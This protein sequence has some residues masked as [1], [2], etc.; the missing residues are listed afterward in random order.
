MPAIN[1][2]QYGSQAIIDTGGGS[3]TRKESP[4][5]KEEVL[6]WGLTPDQLQDVSYERRER[7]K[8]LAEQKRNYGKIPSEHYPGPYGREELNRDHPFKPMS[9]KEWQ[10]W[11]LSILEDM[12]YM[13]QYQSDVVAHGLLN[14]NAATYD[15]NIYPFELP[16]NPWLDYYGPYNNEPISYPSEL[17]AMP[18]SWSET[19][20]RG[21]YGASLF[22]L[23]GSNA[24]PDWYNFYGFPTPNNF[25]PNYRIPYNT[26]AEQNIDEN[27]IKN[28]FQGTPFLGGE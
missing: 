16:M 13:K 19:N 28:N 17:A 8:A 12:E 25:Y 22:N 7:Q 2:S 15:F 23:L 21:S 11:M 9:H 4:P 24:N 6:S 5:K 20:A 3:Q 27:R 18:P 26:G 1:T 10:E 14:P